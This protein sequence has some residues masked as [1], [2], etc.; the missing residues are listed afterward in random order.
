MKKWGSQAFILL[1]IIATITVLNKYTGISQYLSL[2]YIKNNIHEFQ[3]YYDSNPIVTSFVYIFFYILI[4][5][6]AIPGSPLLILFAGAIFGTIYGLILVSI[7]NVAGALFS[8]LISRYLFRDWA[9]KKF[10][11]PFN[12]INHNLKRD[13][14]FYIL[15]LRILPIF[16]FFLINTV[17]GLTDLKISI[18]MLTTFLG[19]L[20]GIIL[21]LV[22]GKSISVLNSL[23]E[24]A[25]PSILGVFVMLGLLPLVSGF[26]IR[27]VK[28]YLNKIP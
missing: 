17:L 19:A 8:F 6:L 2:D 7:S 23:S 26:I 15:S 12:I 16:P 21:Y 10:S 11:K 18:Y 14:F 24:I 9:L 1:G 25:S 27:L 28:R 5:I 22:A 3:M 4:T 13:G 20:P